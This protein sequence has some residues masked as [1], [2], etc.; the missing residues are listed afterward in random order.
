GGFED[1]RVAGREGG[2]HLPARDR[3]REVPRRDQPDDTERLAEGEIDS[4][5]D[6]DLRAQ[7]PFR[8][9]RV[10]VEDIDDAPDLAAR[11]G[12][13]LADV[14]CLELREFLDV[15]L[16]YAREAAQELRA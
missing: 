4:A 2:P 10:V 1:D 6:G 7:K 16:E 14:A 11:V 5:R 8:R 3:K 15:L 12:D 13:R 9:T